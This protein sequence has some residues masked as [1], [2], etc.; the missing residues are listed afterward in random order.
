MRSIVF[1]IFCTF[2]ASCISF[3]QEIRRENCKDEICL[4]VLHFDSV[5][6]NKNVPLK[7]SDKDLFAMLG[8]P[9]SI[10]VEEWP[11]GNYINDY[12]TVDVYY[13]GKTR[14]ISSCGTSLLHI[15]DFEDHRFSFCFQNKQ[16]DYNS[17]K[18]D[19]AKFFPNAV[20]ALDEG[21]ELYNTEGD[22][23]VLMRETPEYTEGSGWILTFR[24]GKIL[25]IE[26]WWGIC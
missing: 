14:F 23:K 9:D 22:M 17:T 25:Q 4:E 12:D 16:I 5:R 26:L 3:S 10:V 7:L 21:W 24:D 15:L 20:K 11:C 2:F 19:I 18:N 1:I 8:K 13:Y 6:L